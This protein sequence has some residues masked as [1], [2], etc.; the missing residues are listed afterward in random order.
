MTKSFV[1]GFGWK[2]HGDGKTIRP[3]DVV[4]PEER[5]SWPQTAGVGMQHVVAMFGA[6][7]LVPVI[8]GFP[9]STTLL[10]SGIGTL[11][12]LVITA[13]RV[14]SYLGSSFAFLAPVGAA[15]AQYGMSGALGGILTAGLGLFLVGLIVHFAGPAWIQKL[16]PPVV[17]GSIVALIGLNLAP[18][19][20]D[21]VQEGPVTATVTIVA[22]LVAGVLFRGMLGRLSILV[23]VVVGYLV[24]VVRGEVDFSE[25]DGAGWVGLPEF[26]SPTFHPGVL[27][28][29]IPVVLVLV[30]ENVGHVKSVAL[31]TKR[32]LDPITGRALMADGAATM[33][34]GSGGGSGTTTYAENIGVMASSKVYSTAAYWVAGMFAI[35]LAL[36]PKFGA[37][38]N[39]VPDGVLGGAGTVLYGMIGILGVRIWVQ[40]KVDFSHPINLAV[41]GVPL[42]IAI[43]DYTMLFGE[44]VFTGIALGSVAALVIHHGMSAIA[45]WRGTDAGFE[46]TEAD[47]A[48]PV[49]QDD[50]AHLETGGSW[51]ED[52]SGR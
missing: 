28:L 38:V 19:A 47:L 15:S 35:L 25:I 1:P 18:A 43:A 14:P 49:N 7:F 51:D 30:A 21:N 32:D 4:A 6:T 2:I 52:T 44:I 13:G 16:M 22:M 34:A 40:N 48:V 33:L 11:L 27:V 12:F 17:T 31:M 26:A 36:V 39:T 24:A 20:W 46:D 5:L 10:F 23:G 50:A 41:A 42:I 9:P 8:T 3:G 29:F 45:R 37:L